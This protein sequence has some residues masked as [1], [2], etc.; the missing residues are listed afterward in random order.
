MLPCPHYVSGKVAGGKES[1]FYTNQDQIPLIKNE[2][3]ERERERERDPSQT[4]YSPS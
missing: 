2:L 1:T 4:S 3:R